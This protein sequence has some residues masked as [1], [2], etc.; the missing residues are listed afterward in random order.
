VLLAASPLMSTMEPGGCPVHPSHKPLPLA[1]VRRLQNALRGL[2]KRVKDK[3]IN[4][5]ADGLVGPH[6]V[7]ATN[8]ALT[9]Y[10]PG[11]TTGGFSK[12]QIL[13]LAP[14]IAAYLEK[15]PITASPSTTVP[16]AP[17]PAAPLP[18]VAATAQMVQPSQAP[19]APEG[20]STMPYQPPGYAPAYYTP[21]AGAPYSPGGLPR[22]RASVDVRAFVP[23]QYEHIRIEPGTAMAVV[24]VG[25]MLAL[26]LAQKKKRGKKED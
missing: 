4:V 15:A 5:V 21:P 14:Q 9:A 19:S 18:F 1:K 2:A 11:F 8:R 26:V 17:P 24:G 23:A 16:I 10:A 7:N 12:T 20:S 13:R 3:A 6:T 25:V 22:D